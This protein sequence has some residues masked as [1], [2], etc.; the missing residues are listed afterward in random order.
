MKKELGIYLLLVLALSFVSCKKQ[1]SM[2]K[3]TAEMLEKRYGKVVSIDL[4]KSGTL[5]KAIK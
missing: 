1:P 4:S 5:S 2:D 3:K